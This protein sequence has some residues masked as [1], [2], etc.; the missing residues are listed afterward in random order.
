MIKITVPL[1]CR[2]PGC[3]A[4][5]SKTW[6]LVNICEEHHEA[7]YWETA[8]YYAESG[9]TYKE[10]EHYLKITH[11]IKA[12]TPYYARKAKKVSGNQSE[13]KDS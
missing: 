2:Y 10:R 6:A 4:N 9:I 11:M 3:K 13:S 8:K 1:R 7:I 5:A 12:I